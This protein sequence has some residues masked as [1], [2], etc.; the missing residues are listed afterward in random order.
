MFV[1]STGAAGSSNTD[2]GADSETTPFALINSFNFI[3]LKPIIYMANISEDDVSEGTNSY[4]EKVRE[5]LEKQDEE[6]DF[7][8][9]LDEH[10]ITNPRLRKM[11][12]HELESYWDEVAY[13]NE[14]A[15]A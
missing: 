7:F 2:A 11:L 12:E 3:T 14:S 6:F 8:A 4:V 5:W 13:A 15:K 1:T 10:K 9:Y